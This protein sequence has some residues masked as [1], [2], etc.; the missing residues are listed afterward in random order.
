MT[1]KDKFEGT[2]QPASDLAICALTAVCS[3][4]V[5][6]AG[7]GDACIDFEPIVAVMD[8]KLQMSNSVNRIIAYLSKGCCEY[9]VL[10]IFRPDWEENNQGLFGCFDKVWSTGTMSHCEGALISR[11]SSQVLHRRSA[12][13][14]AMLSV[15]LV[16]LANTN[17][18]ERRLL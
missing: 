9:V 14:S 10:I 1:T 6:R 7:F 17:F 15:S 5:R 12:R 2:F 16:S 11:P 13:R 4:D 8:R 18:T 3:T